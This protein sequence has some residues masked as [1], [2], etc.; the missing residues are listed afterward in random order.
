M[1]QSYPVSN[2]ATSSREQASPEWLSDN[3]PTV[4]YEEWSNIGLALDNLKRTLQT[5]NSDYKLN[6]EFSNF[7]FAADV[8]GTSAHDV[9]LGQIGI[10]IGRIKGLL[11]K[12]GD[13]INHEALLDSYQDLAGYAIILYALKLKETL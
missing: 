9:I 12:N 11:Q 6:S 13:D 4:K 5:K 2:A 3:P 8:A 10:K 7:Y 1:S